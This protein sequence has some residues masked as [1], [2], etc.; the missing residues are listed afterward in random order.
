MD[1]QEPIDTGRALALRMLVAYPKR[2]W[3]LL[4]ARSHTDRN[5]IEWHLQEDML[6]PEHILDAAAA[7]LDEAKEAP[8]SL[9]T[10]RSE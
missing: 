5:T 2:D 10:R 6:S 7:L 8:E 9:S 3:V 1:A 4:A